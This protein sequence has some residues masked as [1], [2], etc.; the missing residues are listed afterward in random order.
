VVAL[1]TVEVVA[2]AELQVVCHCSY[3]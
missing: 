3:I 2:Y 1:M